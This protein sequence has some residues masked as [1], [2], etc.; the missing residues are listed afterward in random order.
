MPK[1]VLLGLD[2][3]QFPNHS[4][5]VVRIDQVIFLGIIDDDCPDLTTLENTPLPKTEVTKRRG[6]G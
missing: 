4:L 5:F 6:E 3:Q 1:S 2:L